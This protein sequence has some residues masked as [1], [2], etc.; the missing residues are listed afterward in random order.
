M[1]MKGYAA[2]VARLSIVVLIVTSIIAVAEAGGQRKQVDAKT[3]VRDADPSLAPTVEP[4]TSFTYRISLKAGRSFK[5][6]NGDGLEVVQAIGNVVVGQSRRVSN[7]IFEIDFSSAANEQPGFVLVNI[8]FTN[9]KNKLKFVRTAIGI[10]DPNG[11]QLVFIDAQDKTVRD[12]SSVGAMPLGLDVGGSESSGLQAVFVCNSGSGTVSV[13][14][15]VNGNVVTTLA[16]GNRP[17]YVVVAG[18]P[19]NQTAYVSNANSNSVSVIDVEDLVVLGSIAVGRFPQG[20]VVSG[21]PGIDER[22]WVANRDDNSLSVIDVLSNTVLGSVA[23]AA[24]PIGLDVA[25]Q[26]GTQTV[27]AACSGANVVSLVD[28]ETGAFLGNVAVGSIPWAV[29]V[30]G[31][32]NETAYVAN[33]GADTVSFVDLDER[34]ETTRVA[35]GLQPMGITIVGGS[36]LEELFTAN[37]GDGTV[38]VIEVPRAARVLTIPIGGRPR[39]IATTGPLKGQF[40]LATN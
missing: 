12:R 21:T 18:N 33:F 28:V 1:T 37:N 24:A 6:S 13:V 4:G 3:A 32:A 34:R 8:N 38:S 14:N 25:G 2:L 16:V 20:L 9:T 35:V 11:D 23:V 15:L 31:P 36:D 39:G 17:S 26:F 22:V 19:G 5:N 27:V 10:A 7:T 40:V 30:G 29:A